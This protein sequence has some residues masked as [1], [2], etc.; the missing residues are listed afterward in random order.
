MTR[1]P[2]QLRALVGYRLEQAVETLREADL[3]LAQSG[4][5]GAQN[6]AY[7]AM[8][9][10]VLALLATRQLGSSKHSGVL[11]LFDREFVKPGLLPRE[12]SRSLRLAFNRRQSWDYGEV[13]ALDPEE[14]AATVADARSFVQAIEEFLRARGFGLVENDPPQSSPSST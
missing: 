13:A 6:R 8:F 3:L 7:Y 4:W 14:I 9:Y 2:E 10:A 5:R 1:S 12:L 11:A